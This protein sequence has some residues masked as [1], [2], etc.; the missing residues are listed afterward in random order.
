MSFSERPPLHGYTCER[1]D[2][3]LYEVDKRHWPR[4]TAM[5]VKSHYSVDEPV[6]PQ[7][8]EHLLLEIRLY[9]EALF[10]AEADHY[11]DFHNDP[12]YREWLSRLQYRVKARVMKN[13]DTLESGG[14]N[15]LEHVMGIQ[16][17][18]ILGYHGLTI[19]GVE[20]ELQTMLVELCDQYVR[21]IAPGQTSVTVKGPAAQ[22]PTPESPLL[23]MTMAKAAALSATPGRQE[24]TM[25]PTLSEDLGRL[26]NEA[27][28]KPELI[29][30]KVGI[31][32]RNVYRHLSG[33]TLPTLSHVGLY[34][35]ALS[36]ELGRK[37]KLPTPAKRP[38]A[39]KMPDIRQ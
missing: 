34:E 35:A 24:T 26:L 14:T 11:Y 10:R 33:E 12:G 15:I 1:I 38:R 31:D 36:K 27:R 17:A 39:S 20:A 18:L 29:A 28:W 21:G 16:G 7:K 32:P 8:P 23:T 22:V 6:P 5:R 3:E 30:E 19:P 4:I 13:L 25:Q 37:V 2:S 9:A